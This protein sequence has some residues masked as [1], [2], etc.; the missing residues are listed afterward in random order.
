MMFP[1]ASCFDVE[2]S[3]VM[4][5]AL[6]TALE[7]A[8]YALAGGKMDLAAIRTLMASRIMTAVRDGERDPGRLTELAIEAIADAY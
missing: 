8:E 7:E 3:D 6:D 1:T 5:W 4:A 2:T